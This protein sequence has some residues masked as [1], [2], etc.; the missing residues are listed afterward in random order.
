MYLIFAETN[1]VRENEYDVE[2]KTKEHGK[3]ANCASK[4]KIC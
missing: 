3:V 4:T 1:R 2:E